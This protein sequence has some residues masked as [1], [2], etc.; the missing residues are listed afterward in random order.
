MSF[1]F[2]RDRRCAFVLLY[3]LSLRMSL[4]AVL[5]VYWMNMIIWSWVHSRLRGMARLIRDKSTSSSPTN[6]FMVHPQIGNGQNTQ[7]A[8]DSIHSNRNGSSIQYDEDWW[9]LL[10][11]E[12]QH[13]LLRRNM[14]SIVLMFICC[15]IFYF[16]FVLSYFFVP[17]ATNCM[18]HL[19]SCLY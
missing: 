4:S 17:C 19:F 14:L 1:L 12:Q 2:C 10:Y 15:I 5:N 11:P 9:S 3:I 13:C 6:K 16:V 7:C 8:R 18:E